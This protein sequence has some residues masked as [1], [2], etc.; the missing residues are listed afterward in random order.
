MW[1]ERETGRPSPPRVEVCFSY[2]QFDPRV[3]KRQVFQPASY[4]ECPG[5]VGDGGDLGV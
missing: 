4:V 2:W 5:I 3:T 1:A